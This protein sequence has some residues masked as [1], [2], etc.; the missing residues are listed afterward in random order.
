MYGENA[1]VVVFPPNRGRTV[2]S[3]YCCVLESM[4]SGVALVL[5]SPL[6]MQ[7]SRRR[8]AAPV[9]GMAVTVESTVLCA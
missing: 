5:G 2:D 1:E 7:R 9:S 4:A 8:H 6:A 3:R